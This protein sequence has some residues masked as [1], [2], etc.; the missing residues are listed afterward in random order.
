MTKTTEN[1][2]KKPVRKRI[3]WK[4]LGSY[5]VVQVM[6]LIFGI[7]FAF[8]NRAPTSPLGMVMVTAA[9]SRSVVVWSSISV[10]WLA[11]PSQLAPLPPVVGVV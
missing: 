5:A 7:I 9:P 1:V 11:Q 8:A 2:E 4:K 3:N 10:A 6:L